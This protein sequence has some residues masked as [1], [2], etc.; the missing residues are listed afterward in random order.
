M[1]ESQDFLWNKVK[2]FLGLSC[3]IFKVGRL[4][5]RSEEPRP[6]RCIKV[7]FNRLPPISKQKFPSERRQRWGCVPMKTEESPMCCIIMQPCLDLKDPPHFV[8]D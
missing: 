5:N 3:T 4:M 7:S 2:V 8:S 6:K 1:K